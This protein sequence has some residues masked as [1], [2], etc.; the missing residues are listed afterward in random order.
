MIQIFSLFGQSCDFGSLQKASSSG[1]KSF[2][3]VRPHT[4]LLV[5]CLFSPF[6]VTKSVCMKVGDVCTA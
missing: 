5:Y 4:N 3:Q 2:K 6:L 1:T